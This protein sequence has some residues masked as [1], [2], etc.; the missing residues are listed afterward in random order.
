MKGKLLKKLKS[1][2]PIGYLKPDRILHVNALSEGNVVESN[3]QTPSLDVQTELICKDMEPKKV[4]ES[5]GIAQEPD[6]IDVAELMKDLE[7]EDMDFD[8]DMDNKENI[9]PPKEAKDAGAFQRKSENSLRWEPEFRQNRASEASESG[10]G[11]SRKTPLSEIDILSFRKP[12]LNS[13]S[14]FDPNLLAAFEEAVKEHNRI[15]EQERKAR[16]EH[17]SPERNDEE[18]EEDEPPSKARRV[19]EDNPLLGF[20]EKCP[21]GGADSVILYTTTLRGI[22]KTFE[23]CNSIRF[24]LESFRVIFYER[25]VSMHME[26]KEE[27]WRIL[28]GKSFPPRLFV[29]GRYIGGAE[30][31]LTLHEQGKLRPLFQGVPVDFSNGACEG[32]AGVHF[33]LCFN[34]N[35]SHRVVADDGKSNTCEV[36]NENGLIICPYCC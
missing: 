8:E 5:T 13:S 7:D 18:E 32:C 15:S 11:N 12:D 16:T 9:G 28:D 22:R 6:V 19:E 14:L 2:R 34:C 31:V 1:I 3:L 33:V 35:G 29:R 26:F 24:L 23:E 21:P 36:C 17:E 10:L 27:M 4:V 25:D 20:E 30:E